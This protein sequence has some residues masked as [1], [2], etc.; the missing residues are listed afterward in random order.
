MSLLRP[1]IVHVIYFSGQI[2]IMEFLSLKLVASIY[3]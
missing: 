2:Q 3:S 1:H